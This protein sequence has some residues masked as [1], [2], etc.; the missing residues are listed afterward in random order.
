[1]T[2]F[3]L[4]AGELARDTA[5]VRAEAGAGDWFADA[6]AAFPLLPLSDTFTGEDVRRVVL[7]RLG[8]PRHHNA[9]GA[10]I[11]TLVRSGSIRRTGEYRPMR[12]VRSHARRTPVYAKR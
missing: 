9:F 6:V 8:K 10:L 7:D 11:N 5:L 2:L 1:M 3:D 12:D 4:P